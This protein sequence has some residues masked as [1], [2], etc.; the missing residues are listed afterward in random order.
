MQLR[1]ISSLLWLAFIIW[2]WYPAILLVITNV[3]CSTFLQVEKHWSCKLLR[4]KSGS[5]TNNKLKTATTHDHQ[6]SD[7]NECHRGFQFGP[8]MRRITQEWNELCT[9]A[10][11]H[12]VSISLITTHH[13]H[14]QLGLQI[15]HFTQCKNM[16]ATF[17]CTSNKNSC[18]EQER[19]FQEMCSYL[20]RALQLK[21]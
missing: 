3:T 17:F 2:C 13:Q 8:N 10:C 20:Q 4:N 9:L 21:N 6:Q 1:N 11:S 15:Q 19:L 14:T 18:Y 12:N 16:P 7:Y 5:K